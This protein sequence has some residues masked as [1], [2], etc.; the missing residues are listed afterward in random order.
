[1]IEGYRVG[2]IFRGKMRKLLERIV[3]EVPGSRYKEVK[4]W[5]GSTFAVDA[6][7]HALK[8]IRRSLND[9]TRCSSAEHEPDKE[10]Q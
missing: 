3:F 2:L 4:G 7:E 6:P 8:E 5:L 1:M 9:W 10:D